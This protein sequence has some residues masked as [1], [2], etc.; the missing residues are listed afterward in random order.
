M[1][2]EADA[3]LLWRQLVAAGGRKG[4]GDADPWSRRAVSY[5]RQVKDRGTRKDA[6]RRFMVELLD[7]HPGSTLLDIGAGTGAW[8]CLLAPHAARVTA[9]DP[10][11]AM[12]AIL[13][14]NLRAEGLGNVE[15]VAGAWPE[16]EV[17]A[18]DISF[19]S[20]AMYG[21][22]D[23]PR[24]IRRMQAVTRTC[25]VLLMRAPAAD[26]VMAEIA[27]SVWGHPHDS[28]NFQVA[29]QCLLQMGIFA[30]VRFLAGESWQPWSHESLEAALEEV[31]R[32]LGLGGDDR[33][34]AR[35]RAILE[36]RLVFEDGRYVWPAAMRT[37]LV[38]WF[39]TP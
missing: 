28:A 16:A 37:A 31:K 18:H 1:E 29:Y 39:R 17:E 11:P 23:L 24:F 26:G 9:L 20:H 32:R 7:Q 4:E 19:C 12:R 13:A 3:A 6:A 10:S 14:D 8:A 38:H 15:I 2:K 21:V 5:A 25:C 33:H 27:R 35:I 22:L 30:D 34:D 36:R